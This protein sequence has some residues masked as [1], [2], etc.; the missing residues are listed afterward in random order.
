MVNVVVEVVVAMFLFALFTVSIVCI[1]CLS[2]L[3][4]RLLLLSRVVCVYIAVAG[5]SDAV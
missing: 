3:P 5:I 2:L 1:D 4:P